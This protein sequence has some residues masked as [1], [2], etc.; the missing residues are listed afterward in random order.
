MLHTSHPKNILHSSASDQ[1]QT[2]QHVLDRVHR[3][4][5][6]PDFDPASSAKAN[7]RVCAR[8][9]YTREIDGL[10][11]PWP[12]VRT[13][14][15]NPPGGMSGKPRKSNTVAFWA[16]LMDYR[17]N[18]NFEEAIFLAFSIETRQTTQRQGIPSIGEFVCCT[19]AKRLVFDRPDGTPGDAPTHGN[20]IAYV[21]GSINKSDLFVRVFSDLGFTR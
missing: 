19:P 12:D 13:I 6:L 2:P 10:A 1:W 14:F 9:F 17:S 16:K 7:E 4:I 5:G 20:V 8:A 3:V 11:T 18:P 21:P 15:L